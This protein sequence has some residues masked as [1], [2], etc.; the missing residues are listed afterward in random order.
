MPKFREPSIGRY[1]EE[2]PQVCT[3]DHRSWITRGANFAVVYSDC[4]AGVK[5]ADTFVDEHMVY[6]AE[7]RLKI[8]AGGEETIL[9]GESLAIV[10]P[11]PVEIELLEGGSLVQFVT[12][13]EDVVK[14]ASNAATYADGAPEVAPADPWPMPVG[15]Y[16]LRTYSLPAIYASGGMVNAFRTRKLMMCPYAQFPE[17]RDVTAL[18]PHSHQDFEQAS[19]ALE[20]EWVHHMRVPWTPNMHDWRPDEHLEISSPST[21]IIPAGVVHTSRGVAGSEG[22]RLLDVF[23]PPRV[24]FSQK[25]GFVR[26][27]E[28]YPMPAELVPA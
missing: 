5:L 21:T 3:P 8:S 26:N 9:E 12:A 27:A 15:G 11:G 16:R 28:D 23:G 25:P 13:T 1:Y 6:M 10:P 2:K 20:G 7:G 4:E 24:D 14:L 17:A 19:V 18:T 22:W